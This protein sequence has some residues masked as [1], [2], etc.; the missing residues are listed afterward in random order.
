MLKHG[1]TPGCPDCI[2][3]QGDGS[4]QFRKH[5]DEH[6]QRMTELLLAAR[7]RLA[8]DRLDQ[9]TAEQFKY[10]DKHDGKNDDSMRDDAGPEPTPAFAS[11]ATEA[12]GATNGRFSPEARSAAPEPETF[13]ICSPARGEGLEVELHE[14][15][16]TDLG[17][18]NRVMTPE[19]AAAAKRW[20]DYSGDVSRSRRRIEDTGD[21]A[22]DHDRATT[23]FMVSH[24]DVDQKVDSLDKVH[25]IL[26]SIIMSVDV[27]EAFGPAR[28]NKLAA[29]FGLVPFSSL[30]LTDG[31]DFSFAEDRASAWKLI[32]KTVSYVIIGSA[33]MYIAQ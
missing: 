25:R 3:A 31:W 4:T 14:A 13:D 15:P 16:S 21:V 5:T 12:E 23:C 29:K 6:R 28:V 1:N 2:A 26:A 27:T 33:L 30:D 10:C 22:A 11:G 20:I 32:K 24:E 7:Q 19:R 17:L 18:S 8:T 9:W